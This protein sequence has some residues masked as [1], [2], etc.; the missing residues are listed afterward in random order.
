MVQQLLCQLFLGTSMGFFLMILYPKLSRRLSP[1][2]VNGAFWLYF[3]AIGLYFLNKAHNSELF[4]L[5]DC[6]VSQ[7]NEYVQ[8]I[9]SIY[10]QLLGVPLGMR[11]YYSKCA[12]TET[13][14]QTNW[15]SADTV[16]AVLL[17]MYGLGLLW[18]Y[19]DHIIQAEAYVESWSEECV[20]LGVASA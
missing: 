3:A 6:P 8:F 15:T 9:D 17:L 19:L 4:I 7:V 18:F 5:S 20:K 14:D 10:I 16:L 1:W 13:E 2:L 12:D 11:Y